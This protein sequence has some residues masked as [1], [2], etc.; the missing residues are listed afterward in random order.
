MLVLDAHG[1]VHNLNR[2]AEA[3]LRLGTAGVP[4]AL[5]SLDPAL[6][7]VAERV[8]AHVLSGKGPYVPRGFE[9]AVRIAS[10]D[11]DRHLLPRGTNQDGGRSTALRPGRQAQSEGR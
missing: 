5:A 8:R 7:G 2:A 4:P 9:E 6:R 10:P 3:V 11:G 1:G